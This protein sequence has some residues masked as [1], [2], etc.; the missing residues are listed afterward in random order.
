MNDFKHDVHVTINRNKSGSHSTRAARREALSSFARMLHGQFKGIR[1]DNVNDKHIS[2]YVQRIKVEPS[3]RTGQALSTGRLKNLLSH[4]RWLLEQVGKSGLLPKENAR[5]GI[6]RRVYV[7]QTS[8]G[9]TAGDDLLNDIRAHSHFVAASMELSR[10][11]GLRFEE[12][13]KIRVSEADSRN[14]LCLR[15]SW[16][17]DGVPRAIP[18]RTQSQRVALDR[19]LAISGTHSLC[20]QGTSYIEHARRARNLINQFGIHRI[21]G[22]RHSYAQRRY[23]ELTGWESPAAGG[24][25]ATNMTAAQYA[26]DRAARMTVSNELGHGRV[27]VTNVYLG[28]A[29]FARGPIVDDT[30]ILID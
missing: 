3:V 22:L 21:H 18:I 28:S 14:E 23:M 12:S 27:S 24:P 5:L 1:L 17:K 2:W 10:E 16:C 26:V 19:A 20:P 4:L 7:A 15:S 6:P 13:L 25:L 11:F 30:S 8:R 29:T 9:I